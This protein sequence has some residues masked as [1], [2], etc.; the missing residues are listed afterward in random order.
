MPI[1]QTEL[2]HALWRAAHVSRARIGAV[3][4]AGGVTFQQYMVLSVLGDASEDGLPTLEI[5]SRM[6]ERAPAITGLVD[7]LERQGLVRRQRIESDRRQ[8]RCVLTEQGRELVHR[9][10]AQVADASVK[11]IGTLTG[12]EVG[13]LRHLLG[14][15]GKGD[16]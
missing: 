8:I 4:E 13:V 9:L 15:I 10:D 11:A 12:H 14:R 6:V 7:R 3:A 1:S 2:L 16:R 5:A